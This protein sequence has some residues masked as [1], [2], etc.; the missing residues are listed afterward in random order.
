MKRLKPKEVEHFIKMNF[1]TRYI[2]KAHKFTIFKHQYL[3]SFDSKLH[4]YKTLRTQWNNF[5]LFVLF[6]W[7]TF[8]NFAHS[9]HQVSL[10]FT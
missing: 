7:S 3:T 2:I 6:E 8:G 9:F 10:F 1:K 5:S 4:Q